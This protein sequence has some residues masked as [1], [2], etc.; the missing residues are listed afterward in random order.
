MVQ[1]QSAVG[2][3]LSRWW[4]FRHQI[5]GAQ[6]QIKG[7]GHC[8]IPGGHPFHQ[9]GRVLSI[10]M[11]ALLQ[12]KVI[13][14]ELHVPSVK[15]PHGVDKARHVHKVHR[16]ENLMP[17]DF[18]HSSIVN[19]IDRVIFNG[20]QNLAIKGPVADHEVILGQLRQ[21]IVPWRPMR[22]KGLKR[23]CYVHPA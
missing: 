22:R 4:V 8:R 10:D 9:S 15:V 1:K 13:C 23:W 12:L 17:E 16:D 11:E 2:K 18:S 19:Q 21:L 20:L 6:Q 7:A 5:S 3:L 14:P